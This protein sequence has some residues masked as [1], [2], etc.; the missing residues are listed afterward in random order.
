MKGSTDLETKIVQAA[1]APEKQAQARRMRQEMTPAE[2]RLWQHLRRNQFLGLHFRR[3][4]VID[5]FIADFYCRA[6]RLVIECDGGVHTQQ[7][8]YDRARDR[9]LAAHNLRVLRFTNRRIESDTSGVLAQIASA[10]Q[11]H[12]GD[13]SPPP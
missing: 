12:L 8:E 6:V 4:Q 13:P 2:K 5:G 10:V 9:V 3:Q 11:E 1:R 7:A